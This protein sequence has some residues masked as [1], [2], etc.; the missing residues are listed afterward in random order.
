MYTINGST[1]VTRHNTENATSTYPLTATITVK[2]DELSWSQINYVLPANNNYKFLDE[3]MLQDDLPDI[4]YVHTQL[5]TSST[6]HVQKVYSTNLADSQ[7][8]S[9]IHF[10]NNIKVYN[11]R[12]IE[13]VRTDRN[14]RVLLP[15]VQ[16]LETSINYYSYSSPP[17]GVYVLF[18]IYFA[19]DISDAI[20]GTLPTFNNNQVLYSQTNNLLYIVAN[21]Q[22]ILNENSSNTFI[23]SNMLTNPYTLPE[24]VKV[25]VGLGINGYADMK[26]YTSNSND[27]DVVSGIYYSANAIAVYSN[28]VRTI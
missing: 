16:E 21:Q 13:V 9:D 14:V 3:T 27:E 2:D 19:S 4:D 18:K 8:Y 11:G 20:I 17:T 6:D 12:P 1:N 26:T 10:S 25:E 24:I 28:N 7:S 5:S 22:I 15:T 23:D